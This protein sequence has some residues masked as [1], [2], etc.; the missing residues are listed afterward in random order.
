MGNERVDWK[1]WWVDNVA[2]FPKAIAYA[3]A[4]ILI[5]LFAS[6]TPQSFLY[7]KF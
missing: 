6:A 7:F 5:A 4:T 2:L 1:A 3:G